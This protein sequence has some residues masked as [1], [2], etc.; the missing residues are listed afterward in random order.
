[1][2][3]RNLR[4]QVSAAPP[5]GELLTECLSALGVS[6]ARADMRNACARHVRGS[7]A[8]GRIARHANRMTVGMAQPQS[9]DQAAPTPSQQ[10]RKAEDRYV[11]LAAFD[12]TSGAQEVGEMAMRVARATHGAEVHLVHVIASPN[13]DAWQKHGEHLDGF[14]KRLRQ[15]FGGPIFGH[16]ASDTPWKSIVQFAANLNADLVIVAPHDRHGVERF[17]QGSVSEKVAR[18]AHCPVLLARPKTHVA[19]RSTEI[20]PPCPKCLDTQSSS[21]G[22][23][24]WCA[25]HSQHHVKGHTYIDYPESYAGPSEFDRD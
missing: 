1:M 7:R 4:N 3:K 15:V 24:L 23:Q 20:E 16:L 19:E 11:I 6:A 17:A 2:H 10:A 9:P 5:A 25:Q 18:N 12:D 14:A 13:A 21:N 8:I 22:K